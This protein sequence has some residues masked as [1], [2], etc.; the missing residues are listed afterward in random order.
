MKKLVFILFISVWLLPSC[1]QTNTITAPQE[2]QVKCHNCGKGM[3]E[4]VAETYGNNTY[5]NYDCMQRELE[6]VAR[7][8]AE[9][10]VDQLFNN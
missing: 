10:L 5:C 9:K 3:N 4:S 8:D 6:R 1:D 2:P 7:E